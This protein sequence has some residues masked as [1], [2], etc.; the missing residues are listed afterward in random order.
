MRQVLTDGIDEVEDWRDFMTWAGLPRRAGVSREDLKAVVVKELVDNGLDTGASITCGPVSGGGVYVHDDGPGFP[1]DGAVLARLFS[2]RRPRMSSKLM[3]RVTRGMLGHGLRLVAGYAALTDAEIAVF[4]SGTETRFRVRETGLAE[5]LSTRGWE[6]SGTRIE[7]H[8][9]I[10]HA[11][12]D[13]DLRF[14]RR[15]A[16]LASGGAS[17]SGKASAWWFD[18]EA[19]SELLRARATATVRD[20]VASLDGLTHRNSGAVAAAYRG[21]RAGDLDSSEAADVLHRCREL[22]KPVSHRRLGYVGR[23]ERLPS[24]YVRSNHERLIGDGPLA[25][26]LPVVLEVWVEPHPWTGVELSVNRSPVLAEVSAHHFHERG[27]GYVYLHGCGLDHVV[28]VGR[29]DVLIA[30]NVE[31]PRLDLCSDGKAPNLSDMAEPIVQSV[32][33]A[34]KRARG[35]MPTTR[36]GPSQKGYLFERLPSLVEQ[37]SDGGRLPYG[38]RGLYY[39]IREAFIAIFGK[40]PAW[41]TFNSIIR[42]YEDELG[43]DLPGIHRDARGRLI[44]PHTGEDIPLG[45]AEVQKYKRPPWL[46]HR[47]IYCEKETMLPIIRAANIPEKFDAMLMTSKGYASRA[48][49]DLM[50]L[51]GEGDEDI[52]VFVVRD[53][54]GYGTKIAETIKEATKA[55]PARRV[56][57][58][59]LGLHYDDAIAMRLPIEPVERKDKKRR[60][61]VAPGYKHLERWFQKNRVEL[62]AMSPALFVAWLV[63]KLAAY[64]PQKLVPDL[65]VLS[66]ALHAEA[67][68]AMSSRIKDEILL[69]AGYEQQVET[70]MRALEPV[71]L[72]HEGGLLRRVH[73]ALA[74]RPTE[75]WLGPV[76]DL[77]VELVQGAHGP[78]EEDS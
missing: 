26:R 71:L 47:V 52:T 36:R 34:A 24:G 53:C 21:R 56:D 43:H 78:P 35:I 73:A 37:A 31:T 64:P 2:V 77:A 60:V 27:Q 6:G 70:A 30:I 16:L 51:L 65:G 23:L 42:D 9:A 55:R 41:D 68:D 12:A 22:A 75:R 46:F 1:A 17:Y 48:A 15:A 19:F 72:D 62:D 33:K 50:D 74:D 63:E 14:G 25:A 18:Q 10:E 59:D 13:T 38:P 67:R 45:T 32:S 4:S 58:V 66:E 40:S 29:K 20:V 3:P 5:A 28:A 54:D 57:V 39:R 44:H 76:R 8:P 61:P 69:A 7:L 11:F 49:R